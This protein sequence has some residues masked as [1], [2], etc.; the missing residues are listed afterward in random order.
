[1]FQGEGSALMKRVER[2]EQ[3]VRCMSSVLPVPLTVKMRTGIYDDRKVAHSL[4][5]KIKDWGVALMT[6]SRTIFRAQN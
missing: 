6:V 3:I 2:F 4:I 1:M 5:P